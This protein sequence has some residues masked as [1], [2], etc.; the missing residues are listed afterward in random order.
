MIKPLSAEDI[1]N[2]C[3]I[4]QFDFKTTAELE[5]L[6]EVIG[7]ARALEAI[8]FG[9][10]IRKRGYNL[11]ALGPSGSGKHAVVDRLLKQ[12]A[13]AA[14]APF[15]WCYVNN[16]NAPHQPRVLQL[17]KGQGGR[18]CKD[19][20]ALLEELRSIIP[21]A[22]EGDDYRAQIQVLNDAFKSKQEDALDDVRKEAKKNHIA[23]IR[24]PTGFAFAPLKGE[25]VI[26][27]KEFST[28]PAAERERLEALM[29]HLQE[30]LQKVLSQIN[31]WRREVRDSL[32]CLN[33]DVA[34]A[35]VG[36]LIDELREQYTEHPPVLTY[37]EQLQ[38]DVVAN[39]DDFLNNDETSGID[40][41][42][43]KRYAVNLLVDN[44]ATDGA[45]VIFEDNPTYQNLVG[46]IEHKA[47]MG[48]L[49]TDFTLIKAGA[50]QR[51]NN[52]YLVLEA[53][54]VLQNPFAW[55]ALKRALYADEIR[56]STIEQMLSLVSTVS[57]EPE[58]MPLNVKVVLLGD[59][60]LYYLLHQFDPEFKELFKVAADFEDQMERNEN[61]HRLYARLV[62]TIAR[63]ES[64]RAFDRGGVARV[65]EYSTR[66][67]GSAHKLTTHMRS[68]CDLLC[69]ADYWAEQHGR[70]EVTAVD[71]QTAISAQERRS[72]RIQERLLESIQ[73]KIILI[74]TQGEKVGQVNGLTVVDLGDTSFGLPTRITA[75]VRMGEGDVIDIER[76]V[77]LG[78]PIHS[79][80]VLILSSYLG[81]RYAQDFPLALSASL[82]FEQSYGEV[83]GDSASSAELYALLSVLADLPVNQGL[84]VTGSV[85]QFGQVQAIGGVNEKIEGFYDTCCLQGLTGKQ[86]VLI[87]ASN[88]Q[89]L[90]LRAD[91]VEAV[92]TGRFNIYPIATIDEGISLLT[93]VEAGSLDDDGNYPEGTVNDLVF[94]RL[95]RFAQ[96]RHEFGDAKKDGLPS[97]DAQVEQ[98]DDRTPL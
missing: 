63:K 52:G 12:K 85:N 61:N 18:L 4:E 19:M 78:G 64:L 33:T 94:D 73:E 16:F 56:I 72:G 3:D 46:R 66:A 84:A 67:S 15:D 68:V 17:P 54:K 87:P 98:S 9:I 91:V 70:E 1:Y 30:M 10:G 51:A 41:K 96:M 44:A 76:E 49:F 47:L 40:D 38:A 35:A 28:L 27:P 13:A 55:E 21:I 89:D 65:I 36:H 8:H 90:M 25:E 26:K 50:L 92:R 24:T 37:L 80:G 77:E 83:E 95:L 88:V 14:P 97:S 43:A 6:G 60:T 81:G 22:F 42:L 7:Q 74:D 32:K 53:V 31:Q 11:F 86:G 59:R 62:A 79:K 58:A 2:R 5:D 29:N 82:V 93:G 57:I 23:L 34:L 69:E 39:I 48:A 75:Q 71:V 45:P 20:H